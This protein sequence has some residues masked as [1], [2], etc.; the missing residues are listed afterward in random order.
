MKPIF[1]IALFILLAAH[2][3]DAGDLINPTDT[4]SP[5]VSNNP[6]DRDNQNKIKASLM[7]LPLSF[8]ANQGQT[9]PSV[10]FLS[11]GESYS[12]FLTATEA[13]LSLRRGTE[14]KGRGPEDA[15]ADRPMPTLLRMQLVGAI[16]LPTSPVWKPFQGRATT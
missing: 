8:E 11:R 12:L 14:A 1:F 2:R 4:N 3:V 6:V 13:V 10:K 7:Q 9:D 16:Q 5:V 15:A